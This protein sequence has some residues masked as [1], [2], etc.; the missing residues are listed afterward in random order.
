M[1]WTLSAEYPCSCTM[2]AC[3]GD[4]WLQ[5]SGPVLSSMRMF[6]GV[7]SVRARITK[8][9]CTWGAGDGEQGRVGAEVYDARQ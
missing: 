8:Q 7:A 1:L 5:G 3:L 2:V 4:G 6:G 9:S